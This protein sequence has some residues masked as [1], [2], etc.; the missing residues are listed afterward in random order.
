MKELSS[1]QSHAWNVQ[2]DFTDLM[3]TD[4]G[5]IS[6]ISHLAKA[7]GLVGMLEGLN[8]TLKK[9]RRGATEA[10]SLLAQVYMLAKS[11]GHLSDLDDARQDPVFR[12]LTGLGEMPG[13]RRMGEFLCRFREPDLVRLRELAV[14]WLGPLSSRVARR[15]REDQGFV[16]VFI[17]GTDIEVDGK[18]FEGA[19]RGYRGVLHYQ[20]HT[21]FVGNLMVSVRLNGG[22]CHATHGWREQLDADA[23]PLLSDESA[24]WVRADNA[25]YKGEFAEY[26]DAQG[27]DY[28]VSVTN[29]NCKSPVVNI[30]CDMDDSQWEWLNEEEQAMYSYYR[31]SGWKRAATYVVIRRVKEGR[32]PL[33]YP[34]YTVI[35]VS[36]DRLPISEAVCRHRGKQ[37]QENAFKGPLI[38][39][40][41]HHP[42]C[43]SFAANQAYY[44]C[45]LLAQGL[46]RG[47]QY[48]LMP[49]DEW[50]RSLRTIIKRVVQHPAMLTSSSRRLRL[51]FGKNLRSKYK[52]WMLEVMDNTG[53][54]RK[55]HLE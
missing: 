18:C 20:M 37:G 30:A 28:S 8:G 51:A 5:G 7:S 48:W 39:L 55:V 29:G 27:W 31:P 46:L 54:L 23:L 45:G 34:V 1:I 21:V 16:P 11:K 47:L 35:L 9:R 42:P 49:Y 25:Y 4:E 36:T 19:K 12:V 40:D 24:V 44:L 13:S 38:D 2:Y 50:R 52:K 3:L 53:C 41:L 10:Q 17:D 6:F 14:C 22:D 33:L 26:C 32:Q 43:S 15:Y